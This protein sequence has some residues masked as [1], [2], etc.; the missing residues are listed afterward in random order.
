MC[1]IAGIFA[2][3]EASKAELVH[4]MTEEMHHRGPDGSGFHTCDDVAFG[5]RRLAIIDPEGGDQPLYN[6]RRTVVV[7]F[8]GEIY[9]HLELRAWLG[10]RGHQLSSGSDGAVLPHLYEELGATF[11]ER[12]NGI[13]G[14]ALWDQE[15]RRLLLARDKFGVKPLYW[16][17]GGGRVAFCSEL[18]PLLHTPW[19]SRALDY[20]AVDQFM[21][22]RFVPSPLTLL[23]DVRKLRPGSA[24]L[25]DGADVITSQY[26]EA[27][28]SVVE[29][30]HTALLDEYVEKFERAI[31]RQMMSDRPIGVMLSGGVDS[32]AIT[33]AMARNSA[34]VRT[35]TIGFAEGGDT[36]EIPLAK[37]TADLFGTE[38][39]SMV[40]SADDYIRELPSSL[41]NLEEPIGTS[42]ALAVRY[43][44]EL[45]RESVVVGLTGQGADEPL[46]GYWRHLGVKL[47]SVLG[48]GGAVARSAARGLARAPVPTRARRGLE[49][50]ATSDDLGLLMAAYALFRGE[51]KERLYG[52]Q[53]R[54]ALN[55]STPADRVEQLRR[56]IAHRPV[57]DQM[58]YVDTRFWLPEELLLIADKMS[59]AASIELRVPFLDE[60]LVAFVESVPGSVR[61]KGVTRKALH[62]EAMTRWLPKEIVY[63]KERGWATPMRQWLAGELAALV[64]GLLLGEGELVPNLFER[65]AL[66]EMLA[67]HKEGRRDHTRGLFALMTLGL[68]GRAFRPETA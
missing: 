29:R 15:K 34:K 61:L 66:R 59:M 17:R 43:V 24:L 33:A 10:Q 51:D 58:L 36:N 42:S 4:R 1:G 21:T 39:H 13:F 40:L 16:T 57:L 2:P 65:A 9:N 50:L 26:W 53:F 46:A 11:V 30:D 12:L 41:E 48:R 45:M 44:S 38:H 7:V 14:I 22:F 64:E 55:G 6:E 28:S 63:R 35:F 25:A 19:V 5:M 54:A 47:A 56:Q 18:R 68:W 60:D 49:T 52:P 37:Q 32:A 23:R 31:V 27:D 8:N 20:V 3:A 62:K 67:T